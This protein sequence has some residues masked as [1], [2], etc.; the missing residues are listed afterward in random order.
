M[1]TKHKTIIDHIS[2]VEGQLGSIKAE[3]KKDSPDC[4]NASQILYSA[5]RSFASLRSSFVQTFLEEQFLKPHVREANKT[6]LTQLLKLI[7]G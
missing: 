4:H 7:K 6:M 5:T 3:L 1:Y 2:R